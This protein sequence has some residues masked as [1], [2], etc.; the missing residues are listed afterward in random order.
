MSNGSST[1]SSR[2]A[3][4][5]RLAFV[6]WDGGGNV[7]PAVAIAQEL[8]RLGHDVVFIGYEVQR[9]SFERRG[10]AFSPLPRGGDFDIYATADPSERVKGLIAE[11]WA[12]AG[13]VDAVSDA[14]GTAS[15]DALVVDFLMQGA[16]A[17]AIS[18]GIPL[19]VLAHSSV[20]GLTPPPESPM[21]AARLKATND[22]RRTA[23]LPDLAR[24]DAA[25]AG[26]PTIV[27]TIPALDP[28][29]VSAAPSVCYVG[30]VFERVPDERWQSPWAADDERPLVLVSFSTTRLWDQSGRV[31]N[32]L[33]AL[34]DEPVRVLVTASQSIDMGTIPGNAAIRRSVP[35]VQVLRSAALTITHGGHG[36]VSASLAAG[37]PLIVL[38]NAAADQPFLAARVHALGA[39]IALDGNAPAADIRAAT[40]TILDDQSY[41]VAA[42]SLKSAID[43][44]PGVSVAAS[45]A[46][47][48]VPTATR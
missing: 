16:I 47:S 25:W 40:A 33:Q 46:L 43:A 44:S 45:V 3:E 21:G 10:L 34:A 18:H 5:T 13:H 41:R 19:A 15:A 1:P 23:G 30:P 31:R 48:A 27:T 4:V 28:A 36:T 42:A 22:L 11:V 12:C 37:V 6:T 29:A 32:T 8:V 35:H 9:A 2:L 24:L 38:P 39:G 20:A 14:F 7:P 17:S 26:V